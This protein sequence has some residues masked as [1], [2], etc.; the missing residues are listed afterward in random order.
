M[1]TR[2]PTKY[3]FMNELFSRYEAALKMNTDLKAV[4]IGNAPIRV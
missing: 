4:R 2:E 1:L 3:H